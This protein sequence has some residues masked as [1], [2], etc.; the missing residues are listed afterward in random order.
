MLADVGE[1]A[2]RRLTD[3]LREIRAVLGEREVVLRAPR[4]G[5]LGWIVERHGAL[6]AQEYGWDES[7]ERLVARIVA[8]FDPAQDAAWIAEL[9]GSR[10]GC[11]LCVHKD[12]ETARAAHVARGAARRRHLA[13]HAPDPAVHRARR[14]ARLSRCGPRTSSTRPVGSTSA[15]ATRSSTR[16]R[17]TPSDT[18]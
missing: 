6:Y 18:T 10:T 14:R 7:F 13:A 11:V 12:A 2:R 17:T 15:P 5:D 4:P 16:R 9:N 3:A 8:A 1:G